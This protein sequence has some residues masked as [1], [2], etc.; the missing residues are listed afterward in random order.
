M[1]TGCLALIL[2]AL[3]LCAQSTRQSIEARDHNSNGIRIDI[4]KIYD[5]SL[6][7]QMLAAAQARLTSLQLI[8]QTGIAA[9]LGSVTGA[10]QQ[11]TGVA[12][13]AQGLPLPQIATTANGATNS[14]ATTLSSTGTSSVTTAGAPVQ[15]TVTTAPQTGAPGA[16]VPAAT[17]SMPSS[18]SV[19]ASDIL[20]EQMQ[21]TYEVANLRLLLEGSLT[22]WYLNNTKFLASKTRVTVG[23][24]ITISADKRYKDAV[25]IVE[26]MVETQPADAGVPAVTALLPRDKTYNVAA[27]TDTSVSIGAGLVTQLAGISGSFLWGHK[28]YYLVKDQDTVARMVQ[29]DQKTQTGFLWEFR[30]RTWPALR[31]G[32]TKTN[33]CATRVPDTWGPGRGR[34]GSSPD[35]LAQVRPENRALEGTHRRAQGI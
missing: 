6:L 28:T 17:T 11:I 8:D 18:F 23:F 31:P 33:F 2:F 26:A 21:L 3:P 24:P 1:R 30:P 34:E 20:N 16:T 5:D 7:Q 27:I 35:L 19:S 25:A 15:N 9:R 13:S 29:P 14:T 4:P 22:D 12:V 32:G 10:S